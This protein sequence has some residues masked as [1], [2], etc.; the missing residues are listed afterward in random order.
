MATTVTI[1]YN[2]VAPEVT[3]EGSPIARIFVPDD[4]YID[5]DVFV[6]G[7][8][9]DYGKSIYATNVDGLG[10]V[11]G[12]LPMAS[13]TRKF[14]E[15][16]LAVKSAIE[17]I[18]GKGFSGVS[19]DIDG[20]VDEL[21]WKQIAA[22]LVDQGFVTTVGSV[23]YGSVN[24]DIVVSAASGDFW[25]TDASEIQSNIVIKDGVATG[26]L[27][28]I[29]T[30]ALPAGWG[31]GNFIALQ[32]GNIPYGATVTAGI[33]NPVALDNDFNG[34]WKVDDVK[35]FTITTTFQGKETVET[36]DLSGLVCETE[37]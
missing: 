10:T 17:S 26:T 8:G 34:V 21:Y 28:Y 36:I 24:P 16:E 1:I 4:S 18:T 20:Y 11:P 9:D 5:S 22:N 15:F 14:A 32:F 12:L 30:G 37:S 27:K 25:G 29:S 19:F 13:T 6:E 31:P 23:V 35:T 3:P 7:H 33:K 2:R